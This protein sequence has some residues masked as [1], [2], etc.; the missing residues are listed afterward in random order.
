MKRY[1]AK[2][3]IDAITYLIEA[4]VRLDSVKGL[5]YVERDRLLMGAQMALNFVIKE[6]VYPEELLVLAPKGVVTTRKNV[7]RLVASSSKRIGNIDE[8]IGFLT[9]CILFALNGLVKRRC[10]RADIERVRGLAEV[11]ICWCY[12]ID[13]VKF[14]KLAECIELGGVKPW[15]QEALGKSRRTVKSRNPE[16]CYDGAV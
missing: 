13:Y 10:A 5:S 7:A 16:V 6:Y 2:S 12:E 9:E 1:E 4:T 15:L 3:S 11:A 14:R 8:A